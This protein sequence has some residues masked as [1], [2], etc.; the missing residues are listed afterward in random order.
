MD[1]I[2]HI[3]S[4]RTNTSLSMLI[5]VIIQWEKGFIFNVPSPALDSQGFDDILQIQSLVIFMDLERACNAV[6]HI[7]TPLSICVVLLVNSKHKINEW[8]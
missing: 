4:A 5:I 3:R 6:P 2:A 8:Q 1:Y 7:N